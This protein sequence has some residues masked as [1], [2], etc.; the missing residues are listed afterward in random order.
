MVDVA[1][2]V[3]V[4]V[5]LVIVGSA[6]VVVAS[7]RLQLAPVVS[8]ANTDA[9]GWDLCSDTD[10]AQKD[11]KGYGYYDDPPGD[12]GNLRGEVWSTTTIWYSWF[13]DGKS[14]P[15]TVEARTV[16]CGNLG[17]DFYPDRVKYDFYYSENGNDW[18]SFHQ[19]T[20]P[21]STWTGMMSGTGIGPTGSF[22]LVIQGAEFCLVDTTSG[23]PAGQVHAIKERRVGR[24][25]VRH[26]QRGPLRLQLPAQR[27]DGPGEDRARD[28]ARQRERVRGEH[29]RL[30]VH[31]DARVGDLGRQP[32]APVT[33]GAGEGRYSAANNE[34]QS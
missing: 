28:D 31:V 23:C 18:V 9:R 14:R 2:F 24:L 7:S 19:D 16:S 21:L 26:E 32:T 22:V 11:I 6:L 27:L 15:A 20:I 33:P 3:A 5:V 13:K 4:V 10:T 1:K 8:I 30:H 17:L 34:G 25:L 29:R 12:T